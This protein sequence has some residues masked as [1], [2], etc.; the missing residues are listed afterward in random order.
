MKFL[1]DNALSPIVAVELNAKGYDAL[2]VR[3]VGLAAASDPEVFEFASKE[4]RIVVSADTDF[5]LLLALR[6]SSHP[7]FIL[8]RQSDKRPSSQVKLLLSYL[9]VVENDLLS[10]SVVVFE[11]ARIRIRRLPISKEEY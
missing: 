7:S 1:I 8:F 5:G 2:H 9:P 4:D 6:E 10:G 3:E 11:D